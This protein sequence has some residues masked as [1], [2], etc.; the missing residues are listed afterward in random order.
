MRVDLYWSHSFM[1]SLIRPDGVVYDFGMYDGGFARLVAPLRARI[2]GFE[3]DPS[4]HGKLSLPSNVRVIPK[5]LAARPGRVRFNINPETCSSLH[6]TDVTS[7]T[8]DVEALTLND[9]LALEPA[10]R[11]DLIKMDI[12]GE[13]LAVL[14]DAPADLFARVVQMTVE[15]HDF[16]DPKSLPAIRAVIARLRRL[17]FHAIR[18]SFRSY[19]DVLFIN[20]TLAPLSLWQRAWI[21]LRYKYARGLARI[22]RRNLKR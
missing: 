21:T 8:V 22:V 10:S 6:F 14:A 1:P 2:L 5:A 3:P 7:E 19:G 4:W 11:I 12:E 17:G 20:K 18:F 13:E 16:L 15:F 9:A